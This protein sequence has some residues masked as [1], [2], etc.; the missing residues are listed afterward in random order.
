MTTLPPPSTEAVS[1][2]A[3]LSNAGLHHH[4]RHVAAIQARD[5]A[6]SASPQSYNQAC[7]ECLLILLH[8][9]QLGAQIPSDHPVH[10]VIST[11]ANS[12]HSCAAGGAGAL[13]SCW[14]QFGQMAGF[15]LKNAL[16]RPPTTT[17][18]Q[19]QQQR[20]TILPE[21]ATN[22][23]QGLLQ[24]VVCQHAALRNVASTI[25]AT[26]A[27]TNV[28]QPALCI[29]T[30]TKNAAD[31]SSST[32][33]T[34]GT[35]GWPDLIDRLLSVP[36]EQSLGPLLTLQK[37]LQDAPHS[38][39]DHQ[40]D[41]AVPLWIAQLTTTTR[42]AAA[43]TAL[44]DCLTRILPRM[45]AALV[46]HWTEYLAA[47][48]HH[49]TNAAAA[50][51]TCVCRSL[52]TILVHRPAGLLLL[53][54]TTDWILPFVCASTGQSNDEELALEACDFWLTFATMDTNDTAV[55]PELYETIETLL[56]EL[57]PVLLNKMVYTEEQRLEMAA[58]QEQ[59]EQNHQT[60]TTASTAAEKP[61]FHKQRGNDND[62]DDDDD[63][64]ADYD[65]DWT[66]R[67]CAAASLDALAHT[68]GGANILPLLLPHIEQGL[69]R[70]NDP[71]IH[72]ACLLA[73]GAIAGG[74]RDEM[75]PHLGNILPNCIALLRQQ[76]QDN[77]STMPQQLQS[78]A[79]W[80]IS[81][82]APWIAAREP[83]LQSAVEALLLRIPSSP[84]NVQVTCLAAVGVLVQTAGAAVVRASRN[85]LHP[86]LMATLEAHLHRKRVLLNV[87]DVLHTLAECCPN[88]GGDPHT[89]IP[90]L[91]QLWDRLAS[92]DP[93]D[94]TLL[95]LMECLATLA[96]ALGATKYQPFALDTL[97]NALCMIETIGMFLMGQTDL[98]EEDVDP[99]ACAVDVV[100]GLVVCCRDQFPQLLASSQRYE[101]TF[102]NA[103]LQL[104]DHEVPA[105]RA[106]AFALVGDLSR[107]APTL[108]QPSYILKA[109]LENM[110]PA[111]VTTATNAVWAIG[112]LCI[113]LRSSPEVIE[114]FVPHLMQNLIALLMGHGPNQHGIPGL[115]ENAAVC[116]SRVAL[117]KPSFCAADAPRCLLGW[118]DAM[119]KVADPI[120]RRDA[121][122]G[123]VQTI[124]ANPQAIPQASPN[125]IIHTVASIVFA[126]LTWHLKP[127]D[128]AV[129]GPSVWSKT[130][131]EFRP[132]P[133]TEGELFAAMSR[134]VGDLKV[135]AGEQNWHLVQKNLPVKVRQLFREVY[136]T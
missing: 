16:L 113:P 121:F 96:P 102:G 2:I 95:P 86:I 71:W 33:S 18:Q 47:L 81:Q 30:M 57:I 77:N 55:P 111:E 4:D 22:L 104:L 58:D 100:D 34:S 62:D 31:G 101:P 135:F 98:T 85:T 28:Y 52:T 10:A 131:L 88:E 48:R 44:L 68:Y 50:A 80:T 110:D 94:T 32:R 118:C 93:A 29:M 20:Y 109:A 103:I 37:M 36:S 21:H 119:G 107:H 51:T 11:A 125:N 115:S 83:A 92:M 75:D 5:Q 126:I 17:I 73:L 116:M 114:P 39:P 12:T 90:A 69:T 120:E 134:L 53:G 43:T 19:Q 91:L 25:L 26:A 89:Y 38:I 59:E 67:K 9:D 84:T 108:I 7:Y 23:Q 128:I 129:A 27:A 60:A 130:D 99:I 127:D 82:Y 40:L 72:E 132:F 66:V 124:Y 41:A 49:T 123:F 15:V 24:A 42:S 70:S 133:T 56:A 46:A 105:A 79:A 97:D 1:L 54:T 63:D 64:D 112:E 74:C 14:L 45:P 65:T 76:Q 136:Q 122:A 13:S 106:S 8:A 35:S 87:L 3:A 61:V 6:L 117:I 78:I